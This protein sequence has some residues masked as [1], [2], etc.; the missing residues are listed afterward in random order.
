MRHFF[1]CLILL[2]SGFLLRAAGPVANNDSATVLEGFQVYISVNANDLDN[3]GPLRDSIVFPPTNGSA[4]VHGNLV[5]YKPQQG[6]FG[7]DSFEYQVCD[8]LNLC[9]TAEVYVLVKGTNQL[10]VIIQHTYTFADTV[11]SVVL[12]VLS[13]D[14]DPASDTLYVGVVINV[15]TTSNL[16]ILSID[17][18]TGQVVFGHTP[19]TCGSEVF[20]YSVCNTAGCDTALITVNVTCPDSIFL[21]QGFSP[22]GDGI[23]DLLV[24]TGLQYFSPVTLNVFNRYGTSVYLNN[25]YLNDWDGTDMDSHHPLPDGTYFYILTLPGGKT[26]NNYVIINR[27]QH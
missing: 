17:S 13:G 2:L 6:F 15:D 18:V 1:V 21:P 25:N 7:R 10:P 9:A 27:G 3:N 20:L 23:N 16:G 22:N 11:V 4:T 19:L 8:T 5:L 12:D 24:F 14:S 26:Y